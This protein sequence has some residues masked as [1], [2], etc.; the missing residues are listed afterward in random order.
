MSPNPT[1]TLSRGN[2][3]LS[4]LRYE[5]GKITRGNRQSFY[6]AEYK[7]VCDGVLSLFPEALMEIVFVGNFVQHMNVTTTYKMPESCEPLT[8]QEFQTA[9]HKAMSRLGRFPFKGGDE[10]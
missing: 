5:Y 7:V 10:S 8:H 3:V 4:S 9:Y 1:T 2:P 6:C